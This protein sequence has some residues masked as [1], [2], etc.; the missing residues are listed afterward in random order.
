MSTMFCLLINVLLSVEYISLS[1]LNY[2][3]AAFRICL[4]LWSISDCW[5]CLS[6]KFVRLSGMV[7]NFQS[8]VEGSG[9]VL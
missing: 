2:M 7:L 3:S 5:V 4:Y 6:V 9:N 8:H 1:L